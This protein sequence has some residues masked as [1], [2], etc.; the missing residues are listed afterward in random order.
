MAETYSLSATSQVIDAANTVL[1]K[2]ATVGSDSTVTQRVADEIQIPNGSSDLSI[3]LVGLTAKYVHLEF[4]GGAVSVKLNGSG[5]TAIV[6][7]PTAAV[8]GL[9]IVAGGSITSLFISNASGS[10]VTMKRILAS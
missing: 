9:L 7:T 2:T 6:I 10:T 3:S 4:T 8:P 5:N 1:A